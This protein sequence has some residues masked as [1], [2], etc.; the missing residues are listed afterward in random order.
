MFV[1]AVEPEIAEDG[2][3]AMTLPSQASVSAHNIKNLKLLMYRLVIDICVTLAHFCF[4]KTKSRK[5][6]HSG[7]QQQL[8]NHLVLIFVS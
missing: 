2:H 8:K 7:G 6:W 1:F 3:T 4:P 5:W